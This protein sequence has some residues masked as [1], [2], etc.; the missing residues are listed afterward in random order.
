MNEKDLTWY[1]IVVSS[2][3][4]SFFWR[5]QEN[6]NCFRDYLTFSRA[7]FK[8]PFLSSFQ[9]VKRI[10]ISKYCFFIGRNSNLDLFLRNVWHEEKK[11]LIN[12]APFYRYHLLPV[13][14]VFCVKATKGTKV[15]KKSK[16]S[17]EIRICQHSVIKML[18]HLI[19]SSP[20]LFYFLLIQK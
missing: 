16:S 13:I 18:Y 9:W 7:K 6:K 10:Q 15:L 3:I 14:H 5:S 4:F 19:F 11:R 12:L 2:Q 1:I 20:T 8:T 17:R